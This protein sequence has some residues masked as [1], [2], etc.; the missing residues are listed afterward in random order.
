[1]RAVIV[2]VAV[3]FLVSLFGTPIA[4]RVFRALKA[5][6]PIRSIGP[7]THLGKKGTPTMGGVVFI[8][9]TLL[10]YLA[11]H[12]ALGTLPSEQ[13]RPKGPTA[14]AVVLL[15]LFVCNG[16]LGF[17]DDFLKVSKRNSLGLN[18]RAKLIGQALIG[19]VFGIVA[20]SVSGGGQHPLTVISTKV[21]FVRDIGWFNISQI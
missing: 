5:G 6:Q 17:V 21:S 10:A 1:M 15:G 7:Q 8:V 9:A 2:A 12:L 19:I 14:T 11:G 3:A 20:L 16:I 4:I 18:K 13:L